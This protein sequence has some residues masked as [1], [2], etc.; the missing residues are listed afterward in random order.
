VHPGLYLLNSFRKE[1]TGLF[2]YRPEERERKIV[3]TSCMCQFK[4]DLA[5]RLLVYSKFFGMEPWEL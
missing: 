3:T 2:S 4:Y 1:K 5:E